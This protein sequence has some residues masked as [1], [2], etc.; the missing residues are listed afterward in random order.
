MP[1]M[2]EALK[3]ALVA[4]IA[5]AIVNNIGLTRNIVTPTAPRF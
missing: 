5:V 3:M 4:I 2:K 1:S